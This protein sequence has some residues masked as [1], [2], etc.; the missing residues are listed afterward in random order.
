MKPT[1]KEFASGVCHDTLPRLISFSFEL[2]MKL[3]VTLL[4]LISSGVAAADCPKAAD[5]ARAFYSEHYSFYADPSDRVLQFAT[6]GLE[7][8]TEKVASQFVSPS[9]RSRQIR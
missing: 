7:A 3:L 4:A 5:W 8:R 6:P 9:K 2:R 1:P